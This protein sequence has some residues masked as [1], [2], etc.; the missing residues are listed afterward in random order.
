M[1]DEGNWLP[2]TPEQVAAIGPPLLAEGGFLRLNKPALHRLLQD[3]ASRPEGPRE[4][5]VLLSLMCHAEFSVPKKENP[6]EGA[7]AGKDAEMARLSGVD[8][9]TFV[10]ATKRLV[11]GYYL[12]RLDKDEPRGYRVRRP[13]WRWLQS[14][15]ML[16]PPKLMGCGHDPFA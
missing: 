8:R 6:A 5:T 9:K 11:R 7:V 2:L 1:A 14:P 3:F 12:T 10:R 15:E 16:P 13:V 4:L